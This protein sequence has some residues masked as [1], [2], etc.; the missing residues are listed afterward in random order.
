MLEV[1][2]KGLEDKGQVMSKQV[3]KWASIQELVSTLIAWASDDELSPVDVELDGN[4]LEVFF[5]GNTPTKIAVTNEGTYELYYQYITFVGDL[6]CP[7]EYEWESLG[8]YDNA[9]DVID[10]A[11]TTAKQYR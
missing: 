6:E 7:P 1:S 2:S 4:T 11:Q 9:S 5:D 10:E 8:E 3:S